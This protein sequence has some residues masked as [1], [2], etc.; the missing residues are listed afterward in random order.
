[1]K[2]E[3]LITHST[4]DTE[5]AGFSLA[6]TL[7]SGDFVAMFGGLGAGKNGFCARRHGVSFAGNSSA[8]SDLH[9]CQRI[10]RQNPGLSL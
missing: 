6:K 5:A 7:N 3:I 8:K 4:S 10:S 2:S 9:H 1:M